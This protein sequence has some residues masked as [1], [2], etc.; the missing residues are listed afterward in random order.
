M[1]CFDQYLN[2]YLTQLFTTLGTIS[3]VVFSSA[4]AIPMFSYYTRR[5][6]TSFRNEMNKV[7]DKI[8]RLEK[9][10]DKK[11]SDLESVSDSVTEN[12]DDNKTYEN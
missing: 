1:N 8:D 6:Q 3:G 4:F 7:H 12:D 10:L 9:M 11:E 2:T 5:L